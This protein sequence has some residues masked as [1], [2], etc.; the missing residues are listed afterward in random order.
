M[1]NY[2]LEIHT[3]EELAKSIK[4]LLVSKYGKNVSK[5][6]YTSIKN[7]IV[8]YLQKNNITQYKVLC[9][10]KTLTGEIIV[11]IV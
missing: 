1:R 8:N 7:D 4:H 11:E 6:Q 10:I 2:W 3:K 9:D 5:S